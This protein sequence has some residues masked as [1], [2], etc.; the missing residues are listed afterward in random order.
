MARP[1]RRSRRRLPPAFPETDLGIIT[2]SV[3][4]RLR[5]LAVIGSD[6][7]GGWRRLGFTEVERDAHRLF[8]IWAEELGLSVRQDAIGNSYA[9][10]G[11]GSALLMAGSHLDTVPR[12]GN[13]DG[14]AGVIAAIEAAT[15]LQQISLQH[16]LAVVCFTCEEGA[17]FT[18]PCIGSRV[19]TGVLDLTRLKHLR[20]SEGISVVDAARRLG[21]RPDEIEI[22]PRG[23]V[24]CYLELHIEQ[25][26]VLG[27]SQETIGIVNTI[28]GSTR[29]EV[30]I[31]GRSD[32]SGTT[33]MA[34]RQ[35][36]LVAAAEVITLADQVA[37]LSRTAVAT[38]GRLQV[39]PNTV[40]TVP[41]EA[42][43]SIDVRDVDPLGQH[44]VAEQIIDYLGQLAVRRGVRVAT[45][46]IHEQSPIVLQPW[47]G[48]HLAT[49]AEAMGVRYR[50]MS[51]GAGHDAGFVS[52]V[53]P[54]GMLFVPS[55]DGV[56]H[57]PDEWTDAADIA[58][59]AVLLARALLQI[60]SANELGP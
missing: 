27:E 32:H 51:S 33:P 23:S 24:A 57:T 30:T 13:F 39:V 41:S 36:A 25:G 31:T 8:A 5:E 16:P 29:M 10:R 47:V 60:D 12:G 1:T 20:D 52:L 45:E 38:V 19:A 6:H 2:S 18:A 53:A 44:E 34:I 59:G 28:A 35:D 3:A 40:T 55:R 50:V 54:A 11:E 26:R 58:V 43:L 14:A 42:R 4:R 46:L 7:A 17:R 21:F 49:A 37:R 9:Q 15:I 48:E 22:W 56:S